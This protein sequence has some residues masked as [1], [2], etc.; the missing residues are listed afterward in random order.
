M[1]E[2]ERPVQPFMTTWGERANSQLE[3]GIVDCTRLLVSRRLAG[4]QN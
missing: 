3:V 2:R 4:R 1:T